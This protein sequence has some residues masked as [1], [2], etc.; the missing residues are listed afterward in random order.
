[1][2]DVARAAGVSQTTVSLVVNDVPNSNIPQRTRDRVWAAVE[3]LGWRPN[4]LARGLSLRRSNTIGVLSD[5]IATTPHAGR[6][7]QGMQDAAWARGKML[8]LTNTSGNPDIESAVLDMLL[9]RQVD[10]VIYAAMFHRPV[11][12]PAALSTV[13]TVLLDCYAEDGSLPSIV[14]DEFAAGRAATEILLRQGHRQIGFLNVCKLLPAASGRH[15]GYI[16]AVSG[17][18]S[19][20]EAALASA[21]V[22]FDPRLVRSG[23][24]GVATVGRRLALDLLGQANRPT[25]LFCFNDRMAMGAYDAA[26]QLGLGIPRDVA[27]VGVDNHELIAPQLDP[28]LTTLEL[29]HYAMGQWAVQY[30]LEHVEDGR[31]PVPIHRRLECPVIER[32]SV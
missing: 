22:E 6:I 7:I 31:M 9:E 23:E 17:R 16:P 18:Q 12:P 14:P 30:L 21:G 8:L 5:E 24:D 26:R 15:P 19:G 28:P 10:G 1:M 11:T 4:A 13:P 32:L 20:Y 25:G 29:P 2:Y 3:Q 27:I